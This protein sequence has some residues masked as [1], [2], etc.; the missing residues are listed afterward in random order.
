M[1]AEADE[2]H[3]AGGYAGAPIPT[4]ASRRSIDGDFGESSDD[5]AL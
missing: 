2:G 1:D 4:A 5:T 3:R